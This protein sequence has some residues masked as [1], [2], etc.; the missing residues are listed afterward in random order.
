MTTKSI[1]LT[2][3]AAAGM[4]AN[5]EVWDIKF[6]LKT[7]GNNKKTS[8][9]IV[10]AYDDSTAGKYSFWYNK[11]AA[12]KNVEFATENEKDY[13]RSNK[14]KNAQLVWGD[15][16]SPDG[17]LI[18]GG[19]GSAR[20]TSGQVAG[21]LDGV[22]ASGTWT[23]KR[24]TK[25]FDALAKQAADVAANLAQEAAV[26][27]YLDGA[28]KAAEI[29]S[30][31]SD[32]DA[33]IADL[34]AEAEKTAAELATAKADVEAA[35]AQVAAAE[36]DAKAAADKVAAAESE[37][38]KAKDDAAAAAEANKTLEDA[39]AELTTKTNVLTEAVAKLTN[40]TNN[41]GLI[42]RTIDGYKTDVKTYIGYTIDKY[43]TAEA[44]DTLEPNVTN[45][46]NKIA[47][48]FD[49]T[50]NELAKLDT[51]KFNVTA[52]KE[53][54]D[55]T[56]SYATNLA[57]E[58]A[59]YDNYTNEQWRTQQL[60]ANSTYVTAT[61]TTYTAWMGNG[62]TYSNLMAKVEKLETTTNTVADYRSKAGMAGTPKEDIDDY[63][64]KAEALEANIP[65]L[66]NAIA[67]L[68]QAN[69]DAEAAYADAKA[70]IEAIANGTVAKN[71][72]DKQNTLKEELYNFTNKWVNASRQEYEDKF[73]ELDKKYVSLTNDQAKCYAT[74]TMFKEKGVVTELIDG[75]ALAPFD[76]KAWN[77]YLTEIKNNKDANDSALAKI[78][79]KLAAAENNINAWK[80]LATILEIEDRLNDAKWIDTLQKDTF[81]D[82]LND[83]DK[84]P[85]VIEAA[86]KWGIELKSTVK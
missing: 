52:M 5:A 69:A 49:A 13:G 65:G 64:Q 51:E 7:V 3:V 66:T 2:A 53:Y 38:A 43:D 85:I 59:L 39:I 19:F 48:L 32:T 77:T 76:Q 80:D 18:A 33:E 47:K 61:Q 9:K 58:V 26:K 28:K 63:M 57:A 60:Q 50:T 73:A 1:V 22:P 4:V 55:D 12:L 37:A 84:A 23:M 62:G 21:V 74:M 34:K 35:K 27:A 70:A 79:E 6:S 10:G 30:G 14:A 86:A 54:K 67:Q 8:V 42:Q 29:I 44:F 11:G 31:K 24:S 25:S 36:A 71:S 41:E 81:K 78:D 82:E 68:E 15:V 16:S 75:I 20:S 46:V 83:K 72:L 45:A 40:A 17:I 56:V